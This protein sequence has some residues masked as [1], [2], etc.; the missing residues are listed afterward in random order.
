MPR[1][2]SPLSLPLSCLALALSLTAATPSLAT[3]TDEAN[4]LFEEGR[5]L[6]DEGSL[7]A[8]C[9]K[10]ERSFQLAPR[11]GTMLNLGACLERRGQ[12]ARALTMYE[13]AATLARQQ[14][15]PDREATAREYAAQLE[16]KVGKLLLVIEDPSPDAV[17]QVDGETITARSG[18][19]PLDPGE[20]RLVV[21]AKGKL[22][23][24]TTIHLDAG[25]TTT[26]R[27]PKLAKAPEAP[28]EPHPAAEGSS[29][30]RTVAV[31]SG[32]GLGVVGI[33][34]GTVFA[35]QARSTYDDA[36]PNCDDRGCNDRGLAT[37]DDARGQGD[38]ATAAFVVAGVSFAASAALWL[39]WPSG[40]PGAR[41]GARQGVGV[42]SF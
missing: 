21:R 12:L 14:G 31:L 36:K 23:Y 34:V 42:F 33:A 37:I 16:P 3:P 32:I 17:T 25:A 24:E 41:S 27:I 4:L 6:L 7:D 19:V 5:R 30:A 11:L 8:A 38:V 18:L 1:P 35:L 39:L 26:T 13:S 22:P 28:A 9:P 20:R 2:R 10:L 15:R 40:R 29:P